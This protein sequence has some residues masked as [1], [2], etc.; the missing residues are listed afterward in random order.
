M[1]IYITH[2]L[3]IKIIYE[4]IYRENYVY[5]NLILLPVALHNSLRLVLSAIYF[6][7]RINSIHMDEN[8]VVHVERILA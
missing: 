3:Y 1:Y 5:I 7:N 6:H 2:K 4:I 8:L